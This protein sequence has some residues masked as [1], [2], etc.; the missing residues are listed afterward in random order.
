[1]YIFNKFPGSVA[2]FMSSS[3]WPATG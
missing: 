1:M 3:T 2:S